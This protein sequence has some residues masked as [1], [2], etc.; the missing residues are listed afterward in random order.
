MVLTRAES[1]AIDR[2]FYGYSQEYLDSVNK[3]ADE[4]RAIIEAR[5]PPPI[6]YPCDSD[7]EFEDTNGA[8]MSPPQSPKDED[9]LDISAKA[10]DRRIWTDL[11]K[12]IEPRHTGF[13]NFETWRSHMI[14]EHAKKN[15]PTSTSLRKPDVI[16]KP[17]SQP[18]LTASTRLVVIILQPCSSR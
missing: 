9:V 16:K 3:G 1:D 13:D 8:P 5:G 15:P 7:S 2:A 17:S 12:G 11:C 4:L 14:A 18:V 10:W 6:W